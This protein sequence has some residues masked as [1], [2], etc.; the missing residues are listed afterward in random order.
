MSVFGCASE[1][2]NRLIDWFQPQTGVE[3]SLLVP[4]QGAKE[5]K[6]TYFINN[7]ARGHRSKSADIAVALI[8]TSLGSGLVGS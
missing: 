8:T 7:G 4:V 2:R 6:V 3:V 1:K 5:P